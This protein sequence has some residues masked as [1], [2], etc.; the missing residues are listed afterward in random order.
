MMYAR[1]LGL[2]YDP[3]GK[4]FTRIMKFINETHGLAIVKKFSFDGMD[5]ELSK[6]I[7]DA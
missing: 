1:Q 2:K 6:A 4:I 3:H 7:S 5:K